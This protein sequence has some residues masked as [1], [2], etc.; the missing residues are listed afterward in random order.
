MTF[1]IEHDFPSSQ[2]LSHHHRLF[3]ILRVNETK[4]C[5]PSRFCIHNRTSGKGASWSHDLCHRYRT[6]S[7]CLDLEIA[8]SCP[9]P[10]L[11]AGKSSVPYRF[12]DILSIITLWTLL[13]LCS[14]NINSW[15]TGK[16]RS[17]HGVPTTNVSRP[18]TNLHSSGR[19]PNSN[20]TILP[21][22]RFTRMDPL[23]SLRGLDY[24]PWIHGLDCEDKDTDTD[25]DTDSW[26]IA[27]K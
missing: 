2:L 27:D 20:P 6:R 9:S 16:E 8:C 22:R 23:L 10:R 12:L 11:R 3:S 15:K 19:T 13:S 17:Q 7:R 4:W 26:Q 1:N 14:L 24:G 18:S 5:P 21:H 25:T